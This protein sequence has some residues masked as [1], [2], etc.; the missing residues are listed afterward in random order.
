MSCASAVTVVVMAKPSCRASRRNVTRQDRLVEV[1]GDNDRGQPES[2]GTCGRDVQD[3]GGHDCEWPGET[4]LP[5]PLKPANC[6]VTQ[7]RGKPRQGTSV[8]PGVAR[9]CVRRLQLRLRIRRCAARRR[10]IR[11]RCRAWCA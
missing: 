4:D 8:T 5:E 2:S 11:A 10:V 1:P 7:S 9:W 3:G 6:A